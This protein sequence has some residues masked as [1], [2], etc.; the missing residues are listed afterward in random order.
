MGKVM[1]TFDDRSPLFEKDKRYNKMFVQNR[2][3]YINDKFKADGLVILKEIFDLFAIN[4]HDDSIE[5]SEDYIKTLTKFFIYDGEELDIE[6]RE[7]DDGSYTFICET[8]D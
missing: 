5:T 6:Y 1:F 3:S 8:D 2:L 7:N 4:Y